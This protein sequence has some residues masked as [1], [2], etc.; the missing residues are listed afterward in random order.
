MCAKHGFY[1]LEM[2]TDLMDKYMDGHTPAELGDLFKR[3]GIK[4]LPIN[5]L[6]SL[7]YNDESV[8]RLRYLC[9]CANG[10]G[11]ETVLVAPIKSGNDM[12]ETIN[13]INS[14]VS[15]ASEYGVRLAL[16]F[17]S[18]DFVGVRSLER[19]MEVAAQVPG[20]R[21]VIDCAHAMGGPTDTDT[22]LKLNPEQI[23]VV[24]INDLPYKASGFYAD[25]DR[26]WPGEGNNGL[27]RI[28]KNLMA[29]G[30]D[31]LVTVEL[32]N[33]EYWELPVDSI[34]SAAMSKT[35]DFLRDYIKL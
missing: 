8:A 19:A 10:G 11:A 28:F 7:Y 26:L 31:G 23:E 12:T 14:F 5:A 25:S 21:I 34:Y 35:K 33:E 6:L 9:E 13:A 20:L 18:F 1:G 2:Q 22:I 27:D 15:I 16:E 4:C 17:L 29:I 30:Y 3:H 32:F 24:H